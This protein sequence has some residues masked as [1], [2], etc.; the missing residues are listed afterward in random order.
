M[1]LSILG[2]CGAYCQNRLLIGIYLI[3]L[4]IIVIIQLII[5]LTA[6]LFIGDIPGI[7]QRGW[8]DST[9]ENRVI[10]EHSFDC[11]GFINRTD[12][13]GTSCI[14]PDYDNY[15]GCFLTIVHYLYDKFDT[16]AIVA[17]VFG[18][19]ELLGF[20]MS[21]ILCTQMP[22]YD[23]VLSESERLWKKSRDASA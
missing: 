11:C 7:I 3:I 13:P 19:L 10:L 15:P 9:D 1:V 4:L 20:M 17:G 22:R 14:T 6:S 8:T 16:V 5:A 23:K 2:C 21:C 18:G 12:F